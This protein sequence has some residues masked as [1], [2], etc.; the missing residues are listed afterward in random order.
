V[1]FLVKAD[2]WCMGK[3]PRKQPSSQQAL[4]EARWHAPAAKPR[5]ELAPLAP[6]RL[7][8]TVWTLRRRPDNLV[9]FWDGRRYRRLPHIDS[10]PTL[11]Q[12]EQNGPPDRPRLIVDVSTRQPPP[13]LEERAAEMLDRILS[14]QVD[15]SGFYRMPK[16]DRKIGPLIECFVGAK[17]PRFP[18]VFEAL[19]A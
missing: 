16:A 4:R 15:L 5:F 6:F 9:D 18:S 11:P 8:L 2:R 12:V 19:S 10:V 14:L 17:P 3:M 1:S 13:R 7:N